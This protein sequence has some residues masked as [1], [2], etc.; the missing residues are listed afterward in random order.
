[1][2]EGKEAEQLHIGQKLKDARVAKGMTLDDL[3]QATKIQKRYLIAIEDEKFDE[4]PGDFYVRAF[5]KQYANTVGLDGNDLLKQYD[6][7]LPKTKTET[8]SEHLDEAVETRT[9]QHHTNTVDRI[10]QLR[11][12]LP[13]II[14]VFIVV[15]VLGAIWLTAIVRNHNNS[16]TKIDSSSVKVSGE[17][18][19][20]TA[21]K[22]TTSADTIKLNQTQR[23]DSAVTFK[24]DKALKKSTKLQI[25]T[26][27]TSY[28]SVRVDDRDRLAK[29]M[30]KGDRSTVTIA[31]NVHSI[32]IRVGNARNT[33]IKVGNQTLDITDHNRYPSTRTVTI[34][35]GD[36][37]SSS[38]SS[39]SNNNNGSRSTTTTT[40]DN[41]GD[42]SN[43]ATTTTSNDGGSR[44]TSN[45]GASR[46]TT[47]PQTNGQNNTAGQSTG[48]AGGNGGSGS[49]Q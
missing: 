1:M 49:N 22:K 42:N 14:V 48:T 46:T 44:T 16:S 45:Q 38:S 34:Q 29:T 5:V 36:S 43:T 25:S 19:H 17:S 37:S 26:T 7:Y 30:N 28:N 2:S 6:D 40:N 23:T 8:Y 33:K 11:K 47:A 24:S 18:S 20:N 13:T 35:F 41:G 15:V 9:G 32:T 3:Q 21:K 31:K 27:G 39:T 4:L 10:D 12:Y